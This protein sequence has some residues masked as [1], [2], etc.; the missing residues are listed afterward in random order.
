MNND[1]TCHEISDRIDEIVDLIASGSKLAAYAKLHF[2]KERLLEPPT[3]AAEP[4]P[5]DRLLE[6][7]QQITICAN[8]ISTDDRF[9]DVE[10]LVRFAHLLY[11]HAV[12]ISRDRTKQD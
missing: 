10:K 7:S 5:I 3:P 6:A 11:A 8:Q 4:D 9:Q 12:R 1:V 2:L